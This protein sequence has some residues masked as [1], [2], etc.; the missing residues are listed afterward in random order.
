[1]IKMN[2]EI[3][4]LMK[5]RRKARE[6]VKQLE[7]NWNELKKWLEEQKEFIENI[8]TFTI[9]ITHNHFGMVG[10]YKNT[11]SKMQELEG[12]ND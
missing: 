6:K 5:Q 3:N 1:M 10:A 8:P 4:G 11:L 12:N 2:K 9:E 7:T